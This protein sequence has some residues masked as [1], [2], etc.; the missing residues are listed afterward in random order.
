MKK[1]LI[2]SALLCACFLGLHFY[3]RA[4]RI[5]AIKNEQTKLEIEYKNQMFKIKNGL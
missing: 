5:E 1:I 4:K 2:I 3:L